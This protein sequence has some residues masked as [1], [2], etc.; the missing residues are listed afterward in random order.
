LAETLYDYCR[1]S[2]RKAHKNITVSGI[3]FRC[4]PELATQPLIWSCLGV[5]F[6]NERTVIPLL[7]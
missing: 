3:C 6:T 2:D 4:N 7:N 5:P 1:L